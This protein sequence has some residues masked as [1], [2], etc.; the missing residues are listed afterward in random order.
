MELTHSFT[1]PV[2]VDQAFDVLTDIERIAPCMPGATIDSIDGREFTGRV[3]VKVGPMQITYRGKARYEELDAEQRRAVIEARGQETRG[4]GTA[5]ATIRANLTDKGDE[6]EVT[7]VSN[8]SVTGRPAQFG[9]GVM[10]EVGA[11]LLGQFA[12][13]L[14]DKLSSS[15]DAPDDTASAD[16]TGGAEVA[17]G[18]GSATG[19]AADGDGDQTAEVAP[20]KA[21]PES[22]GSSG[23][24]TEQEFQ[25]AGAAPPQPAGAAEAG[26]AAPHVDTASEAP[27]SAP[28]ARRLS[29]PEAEAIDLFDVAGPSIAKRLAPV[30]IVLL[31]ILLLWRRRRA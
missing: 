6:T 19:S 21:S 24:V 3:K 4:S 7:V 5:N 10:N 25:A 29:S 8:L 11:K 14:S 20:A 9:R 23:R 17:G 18:A 27:R 26:A 28:G 13:C 16:A 2:G 30:A 15:G 1:V 12:T 31:I 22:N